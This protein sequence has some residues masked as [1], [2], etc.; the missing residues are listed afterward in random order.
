MLGAGAV[1]KF[2]AKEENI[3]IGSFMLTFLIFVVALSILVFV[4][5][6]GHFVVAKKSGVRVDIFSIGFGPKLF[7]IK[8]HGTEY[9]IAPIPFGGYVKIYGQEPLE[10]AEGDPVKADEIARDP[11][12]FHSKPLLKKLA[13]VFAGPFMNIVLCFAVLP[14]V[15]LW[16]RMQ[17]KIFTQPPIIIDMVEDSPAAQAGFEKGD[18]ILSFEGVRTPTWQD[19]VTQISLHPQKMVSITYQRDGQIAT[20]TPFLTVNKNIKQTAGYLGIEPYEFV[21]NEPFIDEVSPGSPA[22]QAGLKPDDRVVAIDEEPVKYWTQLTSIVHGSGG[23]S[24]R[25]TVQRDGLQQGFFVTPR[26]HED[27]GVYLLGITKK[28]NHEDF[29]KIRHGFVESI[30]LGSREFF[31]LFG[32][33]FDVLGR[34]VTGDLSLKTLGGPLQIAQATSSAARSGFGEFLFLLAFL[35]LQLGIINLLPIP[36]LDGGHVVFMAIEGMIKKPL[37][38]KFRS[39]AMQVGLV[40]LLGLMLL[41][42]INDI[43][44]IWGFSKIV[45]GIKKVF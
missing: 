37:P 15:F 8:W 21:G 44:T 9:R 26:Y 7:G 23:R 43:D 3:G 11:Q 16:G 2:G 22:E 36:V 33:T 24:L 34:L 25:V 38:P 42:T 12:S 6:W 29:I 40:F 31:K 41:V 32:L 18:L 17:P 14:L 35:S 1:Q 27:A 28:T 13:V 45:E 10:E 30:Q 20:V 5:E 39:V 19:L 4:H